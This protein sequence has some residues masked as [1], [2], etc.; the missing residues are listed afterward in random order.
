[1]KYP[2]INIV[3]GL[4]LSPV[5]LEF[6]QSLTTTKWLGGIESKINS[7][8]DIINSIDEGNSKYTDEQIS[9]IQG[10]INQ[11]LQELNKGNIIRDGTID[12][13]KLKPSF[14]TD[15][16][17]LVLEYIHDAV[18]FVSFGL[19]DGRFIAYIPSSW[20]DLQ[21]NTDSE[22]RLTITM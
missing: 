14:L 4:N 3:D 18:K 21:F 5:P 22:G 10:E 19:Q 20:G 6:S 1:M 11:L 16:Q 8:I 17:H 15:L 7:V 9:I 2:H 13:K 12:L